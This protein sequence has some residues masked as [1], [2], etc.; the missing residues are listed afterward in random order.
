MIGNCHGTS[1]LAPSRKHERIAEGKRCLHGELLIDAARPL[2]DDC[3]GVTLREYYN[4]C[5]K[6]EPYAA[7][8]KIRYPSDKT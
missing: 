3:P 1:L 6:R 5:L 2:I 8:F 7:S 4:L